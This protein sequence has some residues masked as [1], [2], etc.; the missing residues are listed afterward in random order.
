MSVWFQVV[1]ISVSILVG[2][3]MLHSIRKSQVQIQDAIFWIF[4]SFILLVF[5]IFP[6]LAEAISMML[7]IASAVNFIFLFIIFLL[8]LHQFQL[9]KRLSKL[10]TKL[11]DLAQVIALD[12]DED[13]H[14]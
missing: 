8:L 3:F 13:N 1:L 9:T 2:G 6:I 5:S 11:K 12:K 4:F 14:D 10:D 7:G